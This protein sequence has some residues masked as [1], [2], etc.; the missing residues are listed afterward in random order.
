MST[1]NNI[2]N[3]G[4]DSELRNNKFLDLDMFTFD[5][6]V[7]KARVVEV[8]DGDT[9]TIVFYYNGEAQKHRLRMYGYDAPEMRPPKVMSNRDLHIAAAKHVR[10]QL[11]NKIYDK[12]VYIKMMK[13]EKYG[14]LMGTVYVSET[15]D[16]KT[17]VNKWIIDKGLGK[18][19]EG[20]KKEQFDNYELIKI[21]DTKIEKNDIIENNLIP[22]K[23][24]NCVCQ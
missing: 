23:K 3:E 18:K 20:G 6:K 1:K 11:E 19:Y 8:Y 7:I 17:N 4:H 5:G 10:E 9:I 14:R 21:L 15:L 13:E 12:I 16:E 2:Y 22:V 24:S